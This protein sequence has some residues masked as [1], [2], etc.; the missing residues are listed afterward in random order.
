VNVIFRNRNKTA[1]DIK[2]L[3]WYMV[4]LIVSGPYVN[5]WVKV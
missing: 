3:H 1:A 5:Y 2:K 4:P